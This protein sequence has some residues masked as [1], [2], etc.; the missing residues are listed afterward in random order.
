VRVLVIDGSVV[1]RSV[2][3]EQISSW[4]M[5]DGQCGTAAEAIEMLRSARVAGDAFQIVIADAQVAGDGGANLAESLRAVPGCRGLVFVMLTTV[6]HLV[7]ADALARAGIDACLAKPVRHSRLINALAAAWGRPSSTE[8]GP[9]APRRP[10]EK[11]NAPGEFSTLEAR[12][13]VV[14]DNPVNQKV[15]VALLARLGVCADVAGDGREAIERLTTEPYDLVLMDCQMP[16]MNGYDATLE[17]RKRPSTNQRVPIVAMTA[18]VIDAA[19]ERALRAGMNDFV[20]KPVDLDD[21]SRA[22]RT[23][24]RKTA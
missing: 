6:G 7:D 15:A 12:V 22:L 11:A 9:E 18:D 14:E 10:F 23:W 2:I 8:A 17:I 24:L 3:H 20:A 5:R 21:L 4:G 16:A 13:L 1:S 19:R